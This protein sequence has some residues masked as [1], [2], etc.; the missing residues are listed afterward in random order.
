MKDDPAI[1]GVAPTRRAEDPGGGRGR[2]GTRPAVGEHF[3][4]RRVA[5]HSVCRHR[6]IP[7]W[8]TFDYRSGDGRRGLR[9]Y[10]RGGG[11]SAAEI[12]VMGASGA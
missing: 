8:S 6:M 5:I 7:W 3:R 2:A 1:I 9:R 10:A 11:Q 4:G 12:S